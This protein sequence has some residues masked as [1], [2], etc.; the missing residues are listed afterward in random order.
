MKVLGLA[1]IGLCCWNAS[2]VAQVG[3]DAAMMRM[4]QAESEVGR[5]S[6]TRD[7]RHFESTVEIPV[8]QARLIHRTEFGPDGRW[9]AFE[10][11]VY[12]LANDSLVAEYWAT[13]AG[14][15]VRWRQLRGGQD[16]SGVAAGRPSAVVPSQTT[17]VFADIAYR[18]AG[19]DTIWELWSP[20][21]GAVVQATIRHGTNTVEFTLGPL[22]LTVKLRPDGRVGEI[23]VLPQRLRVER[24]EPNLPLDPLPGLERPKPDYAPPPGA[25]YTA[26]EVRIPVTSESGDAFELAGTLTVPTTGRPPFPAAVTITGS[27][28]QD[29]DENLW[30]LVPDYRPY[31]EIADRL[32]HARIAVLRVDDRGVGASGGG[33]SAPTTRDFAGDVRAQLAWLRAR[34]EI[35]GKL[36]ALIGHSEG[37]VIGPIVAAED[38]ELAALVIMAGSSQTGEEIIHYQVTRPIETAPGLTDAQRAELR[39]SI[40]AEAMTTLAAANPWMRYFWTYDP[41]VAARQVT[42]PVLVLHGEYDR[43]VTVEQATELADAIREGGNRDV[44]V[45]IFPKLNH[46]FLMSL[47]DGSPHE[48]MA[49]ED[50]SLPS[51]VLDTIVTWLSTKLRP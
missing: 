35:N 51:E 27:G 4:Y 50:A 11:R 45:R 17:A 1:I 39:D 3:Q 24:V 26:T 19:R 42:Q 30:P 9:T 13:A 22:P 36:L 49:I 14:D 48:Y 47:E 10:S 18:V 46:L 40:L 16:T 41:L 5:E 7:A 25:P 8:L 32:A 31:A 34:P 21:S 15:S 23:E 20:E 6:F 12:L 37:G 28:G 33:N 43:Q 2:A 44:T 29:R 38:R